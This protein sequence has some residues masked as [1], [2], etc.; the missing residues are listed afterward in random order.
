MKDSLREEAE[1]EH[2]YRV[3]YSSVSIAIGLLNVF[4]AALEI[5]FTSSSFPFALFALST[6]K[7]YSSRLSETAKKL[8]RH[9]QLQMSIIE[10]LALAIDVSIH[11]THGHVESPDSMR[12]A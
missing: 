8:E 7:I 11:L 12:W 4:A 5:N 6:Y 10:T 1:T 9:S 2:W 3:W